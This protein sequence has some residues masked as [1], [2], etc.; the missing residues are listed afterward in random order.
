MVLYV[1]ARD[2]LKEATTLMEQEKYNDALS[3]IGIAFDQII[4]DYETRK[5]FRFGKSPFHF[6]LSKPYSVRYRDI[7]RD[8]IEF[9]NNS[10]E[11]MQKAT[12]IISLG[13]DYRRYVRFRLLVP[14]VVRVM[15]EGGG[16]Y[17]FPAKAFRNHTK[18][19]CQFCHDFVI[20]S[21]IR[22]QDFDFD[23]EKS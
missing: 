23:I 3:K 15:K 2:N 7:D 5:G 10:I 18:E 17:Y 20:E 14:E 11:P 1:P 8:T 16:F 9:V 4:E 22:I 21:A 19:D 6:G 12:K 13:L